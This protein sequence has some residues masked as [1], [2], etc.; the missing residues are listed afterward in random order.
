MKS[1]SWTRTSPPILGTRGRKALLDEF[2]RSCLKTETARLKTLLELQLGLTRP[3]D[4]KSL[5]LPQLNAVVSRMAACSEL[6]V[7][8][9]HTNDSGTRRL[10]SATPRDSPAP[11][12]SRELDRRA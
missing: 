7:G 2:E 5:G 1:L 3:E 10:G 8:V 11:A 6:P 9:V 4:Q 12:R